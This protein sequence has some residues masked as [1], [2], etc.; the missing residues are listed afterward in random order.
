MWLGLICAGIAAGYISQDIQD[1]E[2]RDRRSVC[3]TTIG[4]AVARNIKYCFAVARREVL[5]EVLRPPRARGSQ[6][7]SNGRPT[8]VGQFDSIFVSHPAGDISR[9]RVRAI[10]CR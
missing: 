9:T 7:T 6:R 2:E 4:L 5:I 8:D 3:E 1:T 10:V